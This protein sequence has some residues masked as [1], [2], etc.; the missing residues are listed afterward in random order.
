ML[1]AVA[2]GGPCRRVNRGRGGYLHVVDRELIVRLHL[3]DLHIRTPGEGIVVLDA[4]A[5][6]GF[7]S[8]K[9]AFHELG[10]AR[11]SEHPKRNVALSHDPVRGDD[12]VEIADVIAVQ[13]GH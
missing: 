8:M 1:K 6:V 2:D 10:G 13:V 5:D 7:Q 9:L 12:V 11:R 4:V 3:G